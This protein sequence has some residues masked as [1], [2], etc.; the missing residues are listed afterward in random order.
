M[1]FNVTSPQNKTIEK[2]LQEVMKKDGI[3]KTEALVKICSQV[4]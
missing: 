2:A 4:K 1:T 3:K